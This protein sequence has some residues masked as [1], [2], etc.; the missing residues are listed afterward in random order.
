MDYVAVASSNLEAVAYDEMRRILGV[1][2]RNGRE[3][4]YHGASSTVYRGLLSAGSKG[5]YFDAFVKPVYGC[6]RVG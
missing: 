1:R 2:F 3:Y 4:W 5:R 6:T